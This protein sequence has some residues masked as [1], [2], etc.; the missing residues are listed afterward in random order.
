VD[1]YTLRDNAAETLALREK[2]VAL[3]RQRHEFGLETLASVRQVEARRAA[4][5][6][7][8]LALDERI[9]LQSNASPRSWAQVRSGP[10]HY[11]SD[12]PVR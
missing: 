11:A 9:N 7:E 12:N 2:T 5:Q 10:G 4:A 3:F 1:L 6:G 8:L